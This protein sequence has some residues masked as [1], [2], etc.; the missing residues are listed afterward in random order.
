MA[1]NAKKVIGMINKIA[2]QNRARDKLKNAN[3]LKDRMEEK[4][5]RD[6]F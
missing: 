6:D 4:I 1:G 3:K 5:N 2:A